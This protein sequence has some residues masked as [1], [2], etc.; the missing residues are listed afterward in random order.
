MI[1]AETEIVEIGFY[2]FFVGH[3]FGILVGDTIRHI[4]FHHSIPMKRNQRCLAIFISI[5]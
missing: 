3:F 5:K 2:F 1:Y 4:I